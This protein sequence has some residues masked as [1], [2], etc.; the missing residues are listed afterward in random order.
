M[1]TVIE[2]RLFVAELSFAN[3]SPSSS[4]EFSLKG[5]RYL[6]ADVNSWRET[7]EWIKAIVTLIRSAGFDFIIPDIRET[8]SPLT[9]FLIRISEGNRFAD[10][11][12]SRKSL[13]RGNGNS[14][15]RR[16]NNTHP[17]LQIST[18]SVY[19]EF[20]FSSSY[21]N[22][23]YGVGVPTRVSLLLCS[24]EI[25]LAI[26]KSPSLI[27]QSGAYL[28]TKMFAGFRLRCARWWPCRT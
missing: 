4:R 17:T 14:R 7:H 28:A 26:P 3:L 9:I 6:R 15:V 25:R 19:D 22:R 11:K 18:A 21:F 8:P 23:I 1:F 2:L 20:C 5:S 10:C 16:R 24:V 12:Y 13:G 27:H